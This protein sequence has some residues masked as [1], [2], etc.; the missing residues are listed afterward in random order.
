MISFAR[1]QK[2]FMNKC[3]R[4]NTWSPSELALAGAGFLIST[5]A[6]AQTAEPGVKELQK[7]IRERDVLIQ[8][9]A[10]R[11]A[12]SAPTGRAIRSRS[13]R[14]TG[15]A[16]DEQ[17]QCPGCACVRATRLFPVRR[18]FSVLRTVHAWRERALSR[19]AARVSCAPFARR[20]SHWLQAMITCGCDTRA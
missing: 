7:E 8:S 20:C 3:A 19:E 17:R 2:T 4:P 12:S 1:K 13:W 10:R 9:L 11:V 14:V 18:R 15:L 5:P 16:G 6:F